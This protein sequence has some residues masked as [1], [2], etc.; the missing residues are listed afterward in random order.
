MAFFRDP[1][2]WAV[3]SM[4]GLVGAGAAVGGKKVG[5]YPLLGFTV[6]AIFDLGR[7]ILVLPSLIQPRFEI[8]GWHWAIGGT[9]FAIGLLLCLP[10]FRIKPFTGPDENVEL[11]TTGF[12]R[13]VR[14]P[15]YLGEILWC[16]GWAIMF[17]SIIG[18]ALVPLW[19]AGLLFH[20]LVEEES[21][22]RELGQTY[23]EYKRRVRGRIVP[24]LPI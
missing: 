20:V 18:V 24:G 2:F 8:G 16:L 19:W 22:E 23:S 12:Y 9:I 14:H 21:L 6:V 15:I 3:I 17:R 5:K 4:F 11:K 13:I 10:A 7:V 1:F